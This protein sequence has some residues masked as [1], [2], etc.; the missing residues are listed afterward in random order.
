ML[1]LWLKAFHLVAVVT[2]FAALFYLP[3]LFV[4]HATAAD[5]ISNERF[6]LMERRL[7]RGIANP[8][9]MAAIALGIGM[10]FIAPGIAASGWFMLKMLFVAALLCYHFT[11]KYYMRCFAEDQNRKSET[12]FRWFNEAPILV[13]IPVCIL[14]VVKPF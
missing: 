12:F 11:C 14:A 10:V 7:Y 8:S 4:Y 5:T 3:R 6:K 1:Y 13:L 9:M 2:W